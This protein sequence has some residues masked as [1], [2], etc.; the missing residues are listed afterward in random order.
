MRVLGAN[1]ILLWPIGKV[2]SIFT[3]V[4][5]LQYAGGMDTITPF[6]LSDLFEGP[7]LDRDGGYREHSP[8][9]PFGASV[10]FFF[11]EVTVESLV[12]HLNLVFLY[13]YTY[14]YS[15]SFL[16]LHLYLLCMPVVVM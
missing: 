5:T 11:R 16:S 9:P 3:M 2:P 8:S 13:N 6:F 10:F 1:A 12:A 4:A 15:F 7:R 14:I